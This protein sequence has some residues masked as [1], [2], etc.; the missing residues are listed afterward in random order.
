MIRRAEYRL[1]PEMLDDHV[2]D[3][4]TRDLVPF[5]LLFDRDLVKPVEIDRRVDVQCQITIDGGLRI[6]PA[7]D[8]PIQPSVARLGAI[9]TGFEIG[10]RGVVRV[11][12]TGKG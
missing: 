1:V 8:H 3:A 4:K 10:P 7:L 9:R 12:L 6:D 5:S 2:G 11:R